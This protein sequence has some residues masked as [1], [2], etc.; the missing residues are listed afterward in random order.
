MKYKLF[1][2]LAK[3]IK[4]VVLICLIVAFGFFIQEVWAKFTEKA[5]NFMQSF[6]EIDSYKIPAVT[7]CFAPHMK[8]SMKKYYNLTGMIWNDMVNSSSSIKSMT[9]MFHESF[10]HIGRDFTLSTWDY[11]FELFEL[12]EGAENLVEYPEGTMNKILVEKFHSYMYGLCYSVSML[13]KQKPDVFFAFGLILNDSLKLNNDEP[14]KL[15]VMF[16]SKLNAYGIVRST[17]AEGDQFETSLS[18]KERGIVLANLKEYR[19][20]LL[21]SPPHCKN[22]SHYEC[23]GNG[24]QNLLEKEKCILTDSGNFCVNTCPKICLPLVFQS[25]MELVISNVNIPVCE[26]GEENK[27]IATIMYHHLTEVSMKCS[28]SCNITQY[29]GAESGK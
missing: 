6:K 24:L 3:P 8:P 17:W 14:K 29:K 20:H 26:T 28:S 4:Y 27:C 5:T 19:Y 9:K 12:H 15:E 21:S 13:G 2:Y 7:F 22:I 18:L 10:Y 23:L 11:K 16:T 1:E 25:L